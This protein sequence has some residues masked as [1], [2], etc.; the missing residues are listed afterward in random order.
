MVTNL[1]L[2]NLGLTKIG[3]LEN[4][5]VALK[6]CIQEL[7]NNKHKLNQY[8]LYLKLLVDLNIQTPELLCSFTILC[9]R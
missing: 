5:G 6:V 7:T 2:H 3:I 8:H 1:I 4:I 9:K